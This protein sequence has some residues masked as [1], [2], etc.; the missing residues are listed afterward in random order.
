MDDK[1]CSAR[2]NLI[3]LEV[4]VRIGFCLILHA[5]NKVI[6]GELFSLLVDFVLFAKS[7]WS[8]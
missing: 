7:S 2:Q 8:A 3:V 1:Q 5:I 4:F 6:N